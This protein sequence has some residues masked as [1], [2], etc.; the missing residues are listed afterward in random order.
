MTDTNV[1]N[2]QER[3]PKATGALPA[4][5]HPRHEVLAATQPARA[6]TPRKPKRASKSQRQ[7]IRRQKQAGELKTPQ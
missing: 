4:P 1:E 6:E 7:H 5:A 3:E 2:T